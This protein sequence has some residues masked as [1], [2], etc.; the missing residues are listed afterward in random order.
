MLVAVGASGV[1][2]LLLGPPDVADML[3]V[4]PAEGRNRECHGLIDDP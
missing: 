2:G 4:L 1:V 3:T